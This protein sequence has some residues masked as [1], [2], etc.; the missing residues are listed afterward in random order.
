MK[1]FVTML[2]IASTILLCACRLNEQ[3]PTEDTGGH[4]TAPTGHTTVPTQPTTAPTQPTT[5]PTQPTT[6]P[7]QPDTSEEMLNVFNALF[8]N[9]GSW[10][11][12]AL[13]FTYS[14]PTQIK[15]ELLFYLGFEGESQKPT[16][17]EWELLKEHS[18][19]YIEMALM[20]LPVDE[21]NRV[22]AELYGITLDDVD[23]AGFENLVYLE[24]TNCYYHM[25]TDALFVEGFNAVAVENMKDGSIRVTYTQ[26]SWTG[27]AAYAVTLMPDGDGYKI[28]SNIR[29]E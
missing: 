22:L 23:E 27:E 13:A 15:L 18:G 14:D 28:L 11:S 7:T 26:D 1:R 29:L 8:G 2:L 12:K 19:F 9:P 16:D 10:Y 20:R 3:P 4:T 17:A 6:V 5:V 25:K 21:M 24:S